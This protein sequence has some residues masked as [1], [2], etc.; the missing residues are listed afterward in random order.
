M[1]GDDGLQVSGG[2]AGPADPATPGRAAQ[3]VALSYISKRRYGWFWVGGVCP[4]EFAAGPRRRSRRP[5][6]RARRRTPDGQ[7][8]RT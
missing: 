6:R 1:G 5:A 8:R 3:Y 4:E 7:R 2:P